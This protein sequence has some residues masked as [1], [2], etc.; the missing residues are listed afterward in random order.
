MTVRTPAGSWIVPAH[1]GVWVPAEVEHS[2][3]AS[4]EV[5][6]R[7]LYVRPSAGRAL[8]KS[9]LV[10]D[11]SPLMRELILHAVALGSLDRRRREHVRLYGLLFDQLRTIEVRALHIPEPRDPRAA[12]V[13]RALRA[14]PSEPRSLDELAR[15][16]GASARTIERCF[17]AE[18]GLSFN[19]WRQQ[20]RL[21]HALCL[22]AAG[23]KVTAVA[24]DVGY[25]SPSAFIAAFR[26][27]LGKTPAR[28][29][30]TDGSEPPVRARPAGDEPGQTIRTAIPL[31][32]SKSLRSLR[33]GTHS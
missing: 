31:R 23:A 20:L 8:P 21:G 14:D 32:R 12:A 15:R 29:F 6:L 9:C 7:T 4:G 5:S 33:M 25:D 18:T 17:K 28:Y 16:A 30:R 11:V 3:E 13:A 26:R 10:L 2:I 1:R 27:V 22:L 19:Q 24:L